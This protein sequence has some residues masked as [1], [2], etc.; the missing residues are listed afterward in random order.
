MSSSNRKPNAGTMKRRVTIEGDLGTQMLGMPRDRIY[1]REDICTY[2]GYF[3][4]PDQ[5]LDPAALARNRNRY[6]R[7]YFLKGGLPVMQIGKTFFFTGEALYAWVTANA[8]R[9]EGLD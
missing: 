4:S 5:P 9:A 6:F 3:A 2:L 8:G 7:D 1:S